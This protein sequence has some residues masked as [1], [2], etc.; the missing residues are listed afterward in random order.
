VHSYDHFI[1]LINTALTTAY[2]NAGL[3][4]ILPNYIVPYFY[5]D[6]YTNLIN[7]IVPRSFMLDV[8]PAIDIPRIFINDPLATYLD[9]FNLFQNIDNTNKVNI[10]GNDWYFQMAEYLD[11][12]Q[13]YYYPPG[14]VVPA[15]T[16]PDG[17]GGPTGPVE[18]PYYFRFKQDYSVL[19]YWSSLRKIVIATNMIPVNNEYLPATNNNANINVDQSGVNVSYPILTDFTPTIESSAG[20]S[21]SIAYYIPSAQYRL[22]DLISDTPL[23]NIDI[24]LYWEDRDGNFYPLQVSV[25]QQSS[26]KLAFVRKSLYKGNGHLLK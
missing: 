23:Q 1:D 9:S 21:R 25:F 16:S 17:V 11:Q 8:L 14:V 26:I 6:A 13:T 10:Q 24:R 19:E 20:S 7:L 18:Y 15:P 2:V 5:L 4:E 3:F 22:V 12:P